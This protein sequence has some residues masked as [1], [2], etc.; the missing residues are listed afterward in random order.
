[1]QMWAKNGFKY[2]DLNND[3][4][5]FKEKVKEYYKNNLV[6]ILFLNT[7]FWSSDYSMF[8]NNALLYKINI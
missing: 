1:M 5:S 7:N 8:L 2:G 6:S 4:K 3:I